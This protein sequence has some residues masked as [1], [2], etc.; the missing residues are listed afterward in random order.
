VVTAEAS[1][2]VGSKCIHELFDRQAE[3]TP[4]AVALVF[5]KE[6][7]SC[8]ELTPPTHAIASPSWFK[9]RDCPRS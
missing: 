8:R 6:E 3:K 9:T 1:I 4:D 7:I 2:D 5:G